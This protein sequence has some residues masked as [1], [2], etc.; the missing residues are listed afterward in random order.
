MVA[1]RAL[2]P[3][4]VLVA[5]GSR[6]RV[7]QY[8]GPL[9]DDRRDGLRLPFVRFVVRGPAQR[10]AD[11]AAVDAGGERG[12][13]VTRFGVA[14]RMVIGQQMTELV[15]DDVVLVGFGRL[16]LEEDVV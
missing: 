1:E 15:Q 2:D 7:V 3:A 6:D 11:G 14:V 8:R 5:G 10:A 9:E 12:Q 16:L 13:E 4:E